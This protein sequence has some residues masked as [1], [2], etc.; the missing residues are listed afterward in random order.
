[1]KKIFLPLAC[2]LT[3]A[4]PALAADLPAVTM[5]KSP[6]CGCCGAWA[7]HLRA[8]GFTVREIVENDMSAVKARFKVPAPVR[9]CHTATVGG[10]V[11]EGHV[12]AADVKRLLRQQPKIAG[13]GAGGMPLGSPGMESSAPEAYD[14]LSFDAAGRTAVFS[15]HRPDPAK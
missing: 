6:T 5:H 4:G 7:D 11:V 14:V 3:L 15:R 12:P 10:Y 8:A 1:M 2:A 9:S 13:I